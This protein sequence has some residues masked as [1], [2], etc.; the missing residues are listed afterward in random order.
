MLR[1]KQFSMESLEKREMM[2]GDVGAAVSGGDLFVGGDANDNL[3]EVYRLPSGRVRV[4]G[5]DTTVNGR[6]Y[7][8]FRV[9]DDIFVTMQQGE[10]DVFFR[11]YNGGVRADAVRI[12]MSNND[13]RVHINGLHARGDVE[14]FTWAGDD[15]IRIENSSVGA[16]L[17][18]RE[19]LVVR[20]GD[21]TDHVQMDKVLSFGDVNIDTVDSALAEGDFVDLQRM[22]VFDDLLV[23]TGE[24]NDEVFVRFSTVH[25]D[26]TIRTGAGAD[27]VLLDQNDSINDLR[28]DTGAG[29][30]TLVVFRTEARRADLDGGTG[31]DRLFTFS[32]FINS[33]DADG[34][35]S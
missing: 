5:I 29:N 33:L 18:D 23:D 2:A 10:N 34:F 13:D 28:V 31:S 15:D 8:D 16:Q 7:Q 30:D 4:Q 27:F 21:G 12:N 3:V 35:E 32:N 22:T 1:R 24:G 26:L 17:F 11:N 19:N 25:D 6:L 20:T 14:I 9:T